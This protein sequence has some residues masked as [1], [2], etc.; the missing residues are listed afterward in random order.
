MG[1]TTHCLRHSPHG[2]KRRTGS[3]S[4]WEFGLHPNLFSVQMVYVQEN[5][6]HP[7]PHP[8]TPLTHLPPSPTLHTFLPHPHYTPPSPHYTPP[9]HP[10]HTSLTHITPPHTPPSL[11][12]ITHLPLS[13]TLHTSLTHITHPITHLPHHLPHPRHTPI[14]HLH[15]TLPPLYLR[16][17]K[18]AE[19]QLG[20]LRQSVD[21]QLRRRCV[22]LERKVK[23]RGEAAGA[24]HVRREEVRVEVEQLRKGL[25]Q[26]VSRRRLFSHELMTSTLVNVCF[27]STTTLMA[28]SPPPPSHPPSSI[29][30]THTGGCGRRVPKSPGGL[31][32]I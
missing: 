27:Y 13:P 26:T 32:L 24:S 5:H 19:L 25:A 30:P 8:L 20:V 3:S 10:S 22:N 18:K 14:T 11:T 16:L 29:L 12:H 17:L 31:Q 28:P 1:S 7:L 6:V 4:K 21:Q 23:E 9:S 2:T 15:H